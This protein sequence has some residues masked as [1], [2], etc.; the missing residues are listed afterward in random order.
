MSRE[1]GGSWLSSTDISVTRR[2]TV[3]RTDGEPHLEYD[4]CPD[5]FQQVL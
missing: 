2:F 1:S 4:V 5:N 3:E